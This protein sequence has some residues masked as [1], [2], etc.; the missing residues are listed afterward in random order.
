M[1]K[2]FVFTQKNW[3]FRA[4]AFSILILG[5]GLLTLAT[6]IDIIPSIGDSKPVLIVIQMFYTFGAVIFV[7]GMILWSEHTQRITK[8]FERIALTDPL[9]G[10]LNRKG[11][12]EIYHMA[13]KDE[14]PFYVILCDL[15]GTKKIND[16]FGHLEGDGYIIS[17]TKII[18]KVIGMSGCVARIGGDEFIIFLNYMKVQELNRMVYRIK[19]MVSDIYPEGNGGISCGFAESPKDGVNLDVLISIADK[20]MYEDKKSRCRQR[21]L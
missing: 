21:I 5:L 15:D 9:T 10:V 7:T 20:I 19:R 18:K 17:T 11:I 3:K 13:L 6:F 8:K 12:E 16:K 2:L 1:I 4:K 14:S